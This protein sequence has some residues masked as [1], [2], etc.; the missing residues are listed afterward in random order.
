[1]SFLGGSALL[2]SDSDL[3]RLSEYSL[4]T[5]MFGHDFEMFLFSLLIFCF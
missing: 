1:M 5:V 4:L 3:D 2:M